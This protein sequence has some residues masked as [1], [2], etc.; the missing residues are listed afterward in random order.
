MKTPYTNCWIALDALGPEDE[1]ADL[2][3]LVSVD[4]DEP[5]I[6]SEREHAHGPA[7]RWRV[8]TVG[9]GTQLPVPCLLSG[10]AGAMHGAGR[11]KT[12]EC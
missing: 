10:V 2:R 9:T 12:D 1:D 7:R 11:K 6:H 3:A 5:E 4:L 8:R